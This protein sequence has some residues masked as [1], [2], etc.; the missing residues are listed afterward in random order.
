MIP[1]PRLSQ[2]TLANS[3]SPSALPSKHKAETHNHEIEKQGRNIS[4]EQKEEHVNG[5]AGVS[6]YQ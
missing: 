2:S 5:V 4:Q 3:P 1:N 6:G